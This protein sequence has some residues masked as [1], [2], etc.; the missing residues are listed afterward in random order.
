MAYITTPDLGL[1]LADPMTIQAFETTNVNS[2]FLLLEAGIVA[3]RVRISAEET[4]SATQLAGPGRGTI[5]QWSVASLAALDVISTAIIGDEAMFTAAPS[6][7]ISSTTGALKAQA[8]SGSGA[9]I[10]WHFTSQIQAA[11]LGNM[12]TF[13]AA[14]VA[15]TDLNT[16]FI[17]GERFFVAELVREQVLRQ[18]RVA[19]AAAPSS[20]G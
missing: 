2:N 15:I 19:A 7:G 5:A 10:K 12:T 14:C 3:D 17:I 13:I 16:P 9:S 6:T 11:T 18:R 4:K 1:E 20:T 8:F